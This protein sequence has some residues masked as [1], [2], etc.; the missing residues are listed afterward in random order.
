MVYQD[1]VLMIHQN[2]NSWSLPKG[3]CEAGESFL[4]TAYREIQEESGLSAFDMVAELGT[5]SRYKIALDGG[6]DLSE[7]KT[8]TMFLFMA[9]SSLLGSIESKSRPIWV[10]YSAVADLLTNKKDRDFYA[11]QLPIIEKWCVSPI[12]QV[13]TT[14]ASRDVAETMASQL[15]TQK[16]AACVQIEGPV[17]S[18]Y[19]WEGALQSSEEFRVVAKCLRENYSRVEGAIK[20]M[21]PYELPEIVA[22]EVVGGEV[23]YLRWVGGQ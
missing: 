21:H 14:V 9:R 4:Q 19:W 7:L 15:V 1:Q 22:T 18:W 13:T 11:A 5:Y 6:D 2:R 10:H 8:M 12:W 20:G 16:L 17:Q 3:H 23:G